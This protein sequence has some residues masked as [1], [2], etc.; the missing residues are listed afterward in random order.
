MSLKLTDIS[1]VTIS[2]GAKGRV[3][4]SIL[5]CKGAD[6]QGLR[7][8]AQVASI[9]S[10]LSTSTSALK[11]QLSAALGSREQRYWETFHLFLHGQLSRIEFEETVR[12]CLETPQLSELGYIVCHPANY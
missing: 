10:L 11:A 3:Q 6:M 1:I 7:F 12:D 9:M 5:E 2:V 8:K 4:E